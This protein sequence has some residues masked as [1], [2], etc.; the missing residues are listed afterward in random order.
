MT[1]RY[2][3]GR[4]SHDNAPASTTVCILLFFSLYLPSSLHAGTTVGEDGLRDTL[5]S[6]FCV[7]VLLMNSFFTI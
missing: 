3:W 5:P 7:H 1:V 2:G 6:P 4:Y